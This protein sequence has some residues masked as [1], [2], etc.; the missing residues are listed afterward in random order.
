MV[1][2]DGAF[3]SVG[4]NGR[5]DGKTRWYPNASRQGNEIGVEIRAVASSHVAGVYGVAAPP[6][7]A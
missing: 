7:S 2:V 6:A 3:V 5:A 1:A 4:W